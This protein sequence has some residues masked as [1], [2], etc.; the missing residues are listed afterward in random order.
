[1]IR[2]NIARYHMLG[3]G[4]GV[5]YKPVYV[6]ST[7]RDL[8]GGHDDSRTGAEGCVGCGGIA[9]FGWRLSLDDI[10]A[11]RAWFGDDA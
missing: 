9:V 4:I 7:L 1:M 11:A 8:A 6:F 2:Q 5:I 3:G 10:C